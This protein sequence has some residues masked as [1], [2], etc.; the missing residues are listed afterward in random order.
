[1]VK[2]AMIT[3]WK[4]RC[5]IY[6][7]SREL[8]QAL[9]ERG[10]DVYVVRL[11]RFGVKTP[12]LLQVVVDKVPR[13]RVD[14]VHVQH[15]YGLYQ[16]LEGGFYA[17]LKGL[18]LPVVTTMHAVG[19]WDVDAVVADVSSRVIVHNEY[20]HEKFGYPEK[21]VVVPHGCRPSKPLPREEA[22]R[23]LGLPMG[24]PIVGYLGFISPYKGLEALIEAVR[25]LDGVALLIGGGYHVEPGTPYITRLKEWSLKV[26]QGRCQW[27]GYVPDELVPAFYGAVDL[28]VYPSRY[29]TE[30]GA[31]LMALSHGKPVIA[32]DLP[33]VRE[34]HREGALEMFVDVGDLREKITALLGDPDRRRRL[35]ERAFRWASERSWSRVAEMHLSLY[36]EVL[37]GG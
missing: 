16:N 29:M 20:C 35:G 22:R 5:G 10:V 21:T 24:V 19:K 30:S 18:G 37:D 32:R 11:P 8:C 14:L 15:E 7:Y 12:E 23:R 26:L 3:P 27:L 13:R 33:P 31:L 34:K 6:T 36:R 17:G 2:I 9:A 28:I 4:V 1:M 25:G